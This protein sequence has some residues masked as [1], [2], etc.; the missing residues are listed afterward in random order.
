MGANNFPKVVTRQRGGRGLNSR[1][2]SHQSDASA[3]TKSSHP[4]TTVNINKDA[5]LNWCFM[6]FVRKH[7]LAIKDVHN[8]FGDISFLIFKMAVV[9]HLGF[10]KF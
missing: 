1:P 7:M 10:L 9:R 3:T 4:L 2:S 8:G 6:M 5:Q